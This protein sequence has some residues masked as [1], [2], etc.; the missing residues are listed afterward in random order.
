MTTFNPTLM[1]P[2]HGRAIRD[3]I[4]T[5]RS[6]Y[7]EWRSALTALAA[8][9]ASALAALADARRRVIERQRAFSATFG[10]RGFQAPLGNVSGWFYTLRS[11]HHIGDIDSVRY[12]VP[13]SPLWADLGGWATGD[14]PRRE[15]N[16]LARLDHAAEVA[17]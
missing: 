3:V 4:E 6:A 10:D 8:G 11:Y 9:D 13:G 16:T 15:R 7:N 2:E 5:D 14:L 12:A 17:R 1:T